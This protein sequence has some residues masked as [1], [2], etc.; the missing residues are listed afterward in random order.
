[1]TKKTVSLVLGSG[2]ARG[3]AH[4]GIIRC[5]EDNGYQ[6]TNIAGASIGALIGGFYA[7]DKLD[8]Y[9]GW[10]TALDRRDVL[11][12]LDLSFDGGGL[13]KGDKI[14][15]VLRKLVSDAKIEELPIEFTAVAVDIER[16]RE[17]WFTEG[18]LFE[19]I[20]AS[21]AIPSVFKPHYYRDMM[22]VDGGVL[23][24]VPMA[25]TL[26]TVTDLTLAVNLNG[27]EEIPRPKAAVRKKKALKT[28]PEDQNTVQRAVGRFIDRWWNEDAKEAEP[29]NKWGIM[30][31]INRSIDTMQNTIA[32]MKLAAH[33]P[34]IL[35]EIPRSVGGLFD[36]NL[37]EDIIDEG[38]QLCEEALE[39]YRNKTSESI[40]DEPPSLD[41][42]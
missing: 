27:R 12:L 9:Q 33:Q 21:I 41:G 24:P 40:G 1:M 37:A 14:M 28:N 8:K 11:R 30:E 31:L 17:V 4:I 39:R 23:N 35:I 20:R 34:D 6:I 18:S 26:R 13:F 16:Q 10:V 36:Y 2:G 32:H 7:A 38:Y 29:Q 15:T 42:Q 19:A 5:L 22:L 3:M 25:P